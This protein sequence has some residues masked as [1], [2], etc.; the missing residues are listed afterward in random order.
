MPVFRTYL[1][2]LME[3]LVLVDRML[4]EWLLKMIAEEDNSDAKKTYLC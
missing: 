2:V 1:C 3:Y 4:K